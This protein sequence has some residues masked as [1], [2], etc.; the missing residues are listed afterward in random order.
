MARHEKT[1][2]VDSDQDRHKPSFAS[3]ED[4]ENLEMLDLER[5]GVELSM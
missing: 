3:T 1:K 4:D 5:R 2:N